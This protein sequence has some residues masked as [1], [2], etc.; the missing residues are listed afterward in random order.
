MRWS[1][2]ESFSEYSS[3]EKNNRVLFRNSW[4]C[5]CKWKF[6]LCS[7]CRRF[8]C[9]LDVMCSK[10]SLPV[11]MSWMSRAEE[12]PTEIS[13][14]FIFHSFV[15]FLSRAVIL[16]LIYLE[17]FMTEWLRQ[18]WIFPLRRMTFFMW[19]THYQRAIL[20]PGW[21]GN[22]MKMHKKCKGGKSLVNTCK[23]SQSIYMVISDLWSQDMLVH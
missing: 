2:T 5:L 10:Y 12:P 17:H 4:V 19:T 13:Y 1:E 16:S 15:F 11:H 14:N 20:A 21:L 3:D 9:L 18:S 23:W 8:A 22:L 6:S 7:C